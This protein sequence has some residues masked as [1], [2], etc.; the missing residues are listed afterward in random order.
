MLL[1]ASTLF[2]RWA[3]RL[4]RL[5]RGVS[6]TRESASTSKVGACT[7]SGDPERTRY[8]RSGAV[9][10]PVLLALDLGSAT[11][12]AAMKRDG[13]VSGPAAFDN[14]VSDH[15][16]LMR[17]AGKGG[18]KV[19]VCVEA[20]GIY[21]LDLSMYLSQHKRAEVMVVNPLAMRRYAESQMKR[22]KT[23]QVDPF[24]ILDRLERMPFR[25]W[26]PPPEELFTLRALA[27]RMYQL[28]RDVERERNRR[29]ATGCVAVH[30]AAIGRDIEVNIRHLE[31]RIERL[32]KQAESVIQGNEE[33]AQ[34]FRQLQTVTGIANVS[35]VHILS[36]LMFLPEDMKSKQW[37]A[38]VGLDPVAH[39]SGKTV[40]DRK[41]SK[42][43][44]KYLRSALY[45]PALVAIR[46]CPNAKAFY[47]KLLSRGK[48]K[49]QAI[50]AVMRKLLVAIWG[51]FKNQQDF[52]Q[53][54]FYRIAA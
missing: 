21:H 28:K 53:E 46:Y 22:A 15:K 14:T 6:E 43:G 50:V 38:Y 35:A 31:R 25:A 52:D 19:R 29:H 51:M 54:K 42:K 47:E 1:R 41:I 5:Y 39:E 33:L 27:R 7:R 23:D 8:R 9:K 11:L 2:L 17:W 26:E 24:V 44:N 16:K 45:M 34:R 20:T 30:E 12:T 40:K 32:Q 13:K 37:V 49:L 18:R 10:D 3:P 4:R 48:E 36:E